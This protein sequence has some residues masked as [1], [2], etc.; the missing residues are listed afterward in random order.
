MIVCIG[1]SVTAA[2]YVEPEFGWVNLLGFTGAGVPGDTT[3]LGLERFP[4][5]VQD[6][7]PERVLIQFGHND[8]NRWQSDCG[9][10]RVSLAAYRSNL[11]E[12]IERARTFGGVPLLLGMTRP[13]RDPAYVADCERYDE[14][15]R[16]VA[17]E[18]GTAWCPMWSLFEAQHF[19]DGLHLNPEGHRLYAKQVAAWL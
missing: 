19:L 7:H 10:P 3:R 18:T 15:A 9:L 2:Q 11:A 6:R 16:E 8:A 4:R 12:M 1:D 5:D 13:V 17:I 14:A